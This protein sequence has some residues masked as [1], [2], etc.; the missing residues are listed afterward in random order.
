MRRSFNSLWSKAERLSPHELLTQSKYT[1]RLVYRAFIE[2]EKPPFEKA[3]WCII[4]LAAGFLKTA[5]EI[6]G[7]VDESPLPC[8]VT[9]GQHESSSLRLIISGVIV[10]MFAFVSK[11]EWALHLLQ[12]RNAKFLVRLPGLSYKSQDEILLS[13]CLGMN[14]VDCAL[15]EIS[16][17]VAKINYA[18]LTKVFDAYEKDEK[19]SEYWINTGKIAGSIANFAIQEFLT[20]PNERRFHSLTSLFSIMMQNRDELSAFVALLASITSQSTF[21]AYALMKSLDALEWQLITESGADDAFLAPPIT[22]D[23]FLLLVKLIQPHIFDIRGGWNAQISYL[24]NSTSLEESLS[25]LISCPFFVKLSRKFVKDGLFHE[26]KEDVFDRSEKW[27]EPILW[28]VALKAI[29]PCT[30]TEKEQDWLFQSVL[31]HS[32]LKFHFPLCCKP[33]FKGN[34]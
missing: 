28:A 1:L 20:F 31:A 30:K 29:T 21:C 10:P 5:L 26:T 6:A 32:S 13:L 27:L 17:E 34:N 18:P 14:V 7:D 22:K 4:D 33:F 23:Y 25:H 24:T 8:N 19:V 2:D 11:K 15:C 16:A 3:T 9:Y 12:F